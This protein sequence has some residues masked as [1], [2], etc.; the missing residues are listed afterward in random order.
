MSTAGSSRVDALWYGSAAAAW[1]LLPLAWIYALVSGVRR[2]MY[3]HNLLRSRRVAVPVIVVGNITAGG[4]GKTPIVAWLAR[5]LAQ[6]GFSPGIVSRGYRG[7]VGPVPLQ[8]RTDSDPARVGDEAILLAGMTASPVI[9]HPDRVAAAQAIAALGANVI[10]CDDG[11]QHYRLSRDVEIA[12]IDGE[13]GFGNGLMLPAGPLREPASRLS[14]VDAV[15]VQGEGGA[16]LPASLH[17]PRRFVL[18]GKVFRTLDDADEKP[19]TSFAGRTVHAVA[20][21]G[22][23]ERFFR[24]LESFGIKVIRHP[25]PDH[26]IITAKDLL[27]G[28]GHDVVMTEKDAVKC[29]ALDTAQCWYVPVEVSFQDDDGETLL[30]L[31][32]ERIATA[33]AVH[34]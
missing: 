32:E 17:L 1:L 16:A 13:R 23:P 6:R 28:D 33:R 31:V 30:A 22:H 9:V 8:A 4:T 29:R 14:G 34:S 26:A 11:L 12:V 21:I 27:F 2:F 19:V 18:K 24:M 5:A 3:T 7:A 25:L 15:L 20:G 10:I